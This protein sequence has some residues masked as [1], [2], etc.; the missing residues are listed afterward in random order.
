MATTPVFFIATS[1]MTLT[2]E[3]YPDG[4]DTIANGSGDSASEEP[5]RKGLYSF[6]VTEALTGLH[7]VHIK[8][9]STVIA[10]YYAEMLD[11]TDEVTCKDQAIATI[12]SDDVYHADIDVTYN[13]ND[14]EDE[15]F[16]TW[17]KNG[18]P[19]TSG[20]TVP[21]IQVVKVNAADLI[22]STTPTQIGSTGV[23][24]HNENTNRVVAG[25]SY[26]V[27]VT[28]TIDGSTRTFKENIGRDSTT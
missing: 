10:V 12:T 15:Y 27:V 18:I 9:G 23:Y 8:S 28:A 16:I 5:N 1:G 7:S 14:G 4:S 19:V 20:I 17:F 2:A 26:T 13:D 25:D 22:A 3:L 21:T 24:R 11:T 6:D